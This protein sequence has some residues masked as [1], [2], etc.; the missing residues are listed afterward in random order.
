MMLGYLGLSYAIRCSLAELEK[1]GSAVSPPK[2]FIRLVNWLPEPGGCLLLGLSALAL[3]YARVGFVEGGGL[4]TSRLLLLVLVGL[5]VML[6]VAV[7]PLIAL[8]LPQPAQIEGVTELD[9]MAFL[10]VTLVL[11]VCSF[12]YIKARPADR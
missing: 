4:K 6:A 3:A 2:V 10:L 9:E 1:W 5:M 12:R 7:L 11:C 8:L